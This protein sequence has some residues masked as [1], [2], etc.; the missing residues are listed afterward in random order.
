MLREENPS[1]RHCAKR[2]KVNKMI[3][4]CGFVKFFYGHQDGSRPMKRMQPSERDIWPHAGM[5]GKEAEE[6]QY[7]SRRSGKKE[8]PDIEPPE[9]GL[10]AGFDK[11]Q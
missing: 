6:E 1:D 4:I 10:L 9:A 8:Q 11:G 2:R 3:T 7:A 5:Y